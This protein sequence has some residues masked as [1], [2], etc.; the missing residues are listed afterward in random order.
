MCYLPQLPRSRLAW[1]CIR[2]GAAARCTPT[3]ASLPCLEQQRGWCGSCMMVVV[4]ELASPDQA[5]CAVQRF[6]RSNVCVADGRAVSS[7]AL[8]HRGGTRRRASSGPARSSGHYTPIK[9]AWMPVKRVGA[10]VRWPPAFPGFRLL[11]WGAAA[12]L[13]PGA[14]HTTSPARHPRAGAP[15][16]HI[17][18]CPY[19]ARAIAAYAQ[20]T[21]QH[22][23]TT[24]PLPPPNAPNQPTW[25]VAR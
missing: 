14:H 17:C 24:Q 5:V 22:P 3:A 10:F 6:G 15:S 19:S 25:V 9:G 4:L 1:R 12:D 23:S 7:G 13:L 18:P 11:T 21:C 8:T 16:A 20:A 2:W